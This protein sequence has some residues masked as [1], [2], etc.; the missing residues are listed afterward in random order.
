[1]G[2][3]WS[4]YPKAVS[5]LIPG[6]PSPH[7]LMQDMARFFLF[8]RLEPGCKDLYSKFLVALESAWKR[9]ETCIATLNYE[10]LV[11]QAMTG[12]GWRPR[13]LRPHGGCQF[14]PQGRIFGPAPGQAP[15][16][17]LNLTSHR[18]RDLWH[19]VFTRSILRE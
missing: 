9:D 18:I 8:Y 16:Q 6:A 5:P 2:V 14:W 11:D 1:M 15:G 4:M 3:L 12:L 10:H 7:E 19:L 17:G 13:V